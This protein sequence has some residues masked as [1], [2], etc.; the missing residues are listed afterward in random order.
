MKYPLTASQ[1]EILNFISWEIL[2]KQRPPSARE[3]CTRFGF[4]STNAAYDHL[5]ALEKKGLIVIEPMLSRGIRV[6]GLACPHCH[7]E[8]SP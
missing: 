7:H 6:V 5:R 4:K 3:I 1:Q 2:T 8:V